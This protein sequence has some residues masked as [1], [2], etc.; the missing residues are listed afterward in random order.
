MFYPIFLSDKI[1]MER[2][3]YV[4]IDTIPEK[5]QLSEQ[6]GSGILYECDTIVTLDSQSRLEFVKQRCRTN[7]RLFQLGVPG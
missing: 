5:Y 3:T 1:S 4:L 2:R 7:G 6:C